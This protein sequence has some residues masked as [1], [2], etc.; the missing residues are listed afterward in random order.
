[1][2]ESRLFVALDQR[3][4]VQ[5]GTGQNNYKGLGET[6][7]DY[8]YV[9]CSDG[10]TCVCV[11]VC[12]YIHIYIYMYIYICMTNFATLLPRM[13][14]WLAVRYTGIAENLSFSW[15]VSRE[16]TFTLRLSQSWDRKHLGLI[17]GQQ[18][19]QH[20]STSS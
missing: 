13:E 20:S 18:G 3:I 6:L 16:P 14:S 12:V 8:E 9:L 17:R 15:L 2:T 4:S 7:G 1:M 19:F 10:F 5:E 11:C